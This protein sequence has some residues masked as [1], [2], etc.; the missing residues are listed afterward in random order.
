MQPPSNFCTFE[1][2]LTFRFLFAYNITHRRSEKDGPPPIAN[3]QAFQPRM[4]FFR[5]LCPPNFSLMI[6][7]VFASGPSNVGRSKHSVNRL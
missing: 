7:A 2:S 5:T 4:L 1:G 6:T 3:A